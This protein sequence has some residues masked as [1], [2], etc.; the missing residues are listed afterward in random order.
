MNI[1]KRVINSLATSFLCASSI[2]TLASE[3]PFK[4][5][6][7]ENAVGTKDIAAG[8]YAKFINS[9]STENSI[10]SAFERN[11]SLCAAYIKTAAY[12]KAESTCT[13][14]I[15]DLK[16]IALPRKKSLYLKS[17]SLSNRGVSRYLNKDITG[18]MDDF[19]TAM[20]TD[21]N[22][23]TKNNLSI[24]KHASL[25]DDEKSSIVLSD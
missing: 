9:R 15:N 18:S 7:I 21:S 25:K 23:I 16:S 12:N 13:A 10:H 22:T 17:L 24:A 1:K 6:I 5:A 2:S 11:M 8:D 20:L 19:T 3:A 14:A 4:L